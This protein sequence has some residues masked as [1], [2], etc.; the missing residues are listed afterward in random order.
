M[1][2]RPTAEDLPNAVVPVLRS[3][4][5]DAESARV[6][7]WSASPRGLATETFLF[8]LERADAEPVSLVLRRPPEVALFPDY[9]LLR[10]VLV[11]RRL[12]ETSIAVPAVRW[13]DRDDAAL[14]SPYFVMDRIDGSAPGDLPSYHS[15]GL[16]FD[17]DPADRAKMWWGC[18]DTIAEIH[19]LDWRNLN[20]D[21]LS[22]PKFG[23]APLEQMI[24]YVDSALAW[25][26]TTQPPALRRAVEWLRANLYEP[27][28]ITLC[29]GD[30]RMSN[31]L[32]DKEFRVSG[33]LD[34]EIAYIGDHEADLAWMLF[35]D[36]ACSE[37]QGTERLAGTPSREES[38]AR[39]EERSG[40]KI[41][42]L[43]YNEV[44]A[45]VLL[46]IPLLRMAH[47]LNLPSEID[48][49]AFCTQRVEQLL[50]DE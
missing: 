34:W 37:F 29:W 30:A 47:R 45:A 5:P 43:R 8:D 19:Q 20:L 1:T 36:W 23:A 41:R 25:A 17:A 48:I 3:G 27:E 46:S 49:T 6:T 21:F 39:Y 32:Y 2:N 24:G 15:A 40:M 13:L 22:F 18:V 35:L 33:V 42:N 4:F 9:D 28:H 7:N 44:L 10:Q 26:T 12:A 11:M 16:Y 38:I 31:I 50:G 14:G